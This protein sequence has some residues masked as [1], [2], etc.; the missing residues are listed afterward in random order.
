MCL[1]GI[2]KQISDRLN[3]IDVT[4]NNNN[5]SYD[6]VDHCDYLELENITPETLP[7]DNLNLLQI[8]VRGI[9]GKQN[10]LHSLLDK[11]ESFSDIHCLLLCE[12]WLTEDTKKLISFNNHRFLGKERSMKKGGGVGFLIRSDLIVREREDFHFSYCS[13]NCC[14]FSCCRWLCCCWYPCRILATAGTTEPITSAEAEGHT[15]MCA[16]N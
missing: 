5:D 11:L 6:F 8:N 4:N 7:K 16:V 2:K 14:C 15:V 9:V 10:K 13:S 3:N 1:Q 12:T